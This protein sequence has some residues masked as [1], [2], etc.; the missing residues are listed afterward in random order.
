MS[1]QAI[2][3]PRILGFLLA[4]IVLL[5]SVEHSNISAKKKMKPEEFV[6]LHLDSIGSP[7]ARSGRTNCTAKGVADFQVLVGTGRQLQGESTFY[8]D[9][10]KYRSS[11]IFPVADYPGEELSFDGK[12]TYVKQLNPGEHSKIGKFLYRYEVLLKEGLIGGTLSTAWPLLDIKNRKP[13]LKYTGIKK[14]GDRELH[15]LEYRFRRGGGDFKIRLYF[16]PETYQHVITL[17]RLV[18]PESQRMTAISGADRAADTARRSPTTYVLEEHFGDYREI[19]GLNIPFLWF[20]RFTADEAAAGVGS[21]VAAT[22]DRSV[23]QWEV[24]FRTV[25]HNTPIDAET[26]KLY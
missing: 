23:V 26:F 18:I 17:Y 2:R 11:I 1:N 16:H 9:G 5:V 7:E 13:K 15:E 21:V 12:K 8:S 3:L 22:R 4:V 6:A 10:T 20:L 14:L 25:E 24:R 19:D